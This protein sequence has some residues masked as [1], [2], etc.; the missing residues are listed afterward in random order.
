M[1]RNTIVWLTL[2]ALT[3]ASVTLSHAAFRRSYLIAGILGF[4]LV[5]FLGVAFQF[6]EI[7][8]AHR[9]W[10]ILLILFGVSFTVLAYAVS[11]G[12]VSL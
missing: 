2:I 7:R 12:G 5:K 3:A 4:A 8:T 11:R 6:M 1:E 10:K 9:G